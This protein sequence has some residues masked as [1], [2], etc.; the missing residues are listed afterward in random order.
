MLSNEQEIT[1]RSKINTQIYQFYQYL[2][3]EKQTSY[4][5]SLCDFLNNYPFLHLIRKNHLVKSRGNDGLTKEFYC[6]IWDSIENTFV[7][8]I[9]I[10]KTYLCFTT[11]ITS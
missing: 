5:D 11:T 6:M 7:E 10:A 3:K 1:H 9:K 8:R 4:K 2:H